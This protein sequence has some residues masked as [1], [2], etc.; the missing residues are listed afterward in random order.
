MAKRVLDTQ[1]CFSGA[2][3]GFLPLVEVDFA[4]VNGAAYVPPERG[5]Y[6]RINAARTIQ[7]LQDVPELIH[8]YQTSD[9][10]I[11]L[12]SNQIGTDES[13]ND[14]GNGRG[15]RFKNEGTGAIYIGT[16]A[17]ILLVTVP[18]LYSVNVQASENQQWDI[19][20]LSNENPSALPISVITFSRSQTVSQG[21]YLYIGSNLTSDCGFPLNAVTYVSAISVTN[22]KSMVAGKSATFRLQKRIAENVF[23]DIIG[24]D[25]TIPAGSYKATINGLLLQLNTGDELCAYRINGDG[26]GN[27]N[28]CV[29]NAYTI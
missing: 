17:G 28:G 22:Q 14:A 5:N 16:S 23:T 7:L 3:F 4:A 26:G 27:V 11:R 12:P 29:Y 21:S 24:S 10:Y 13:G 9:A 25:V 8:T 1:H 6:R 18:P 2:A 20:A 15:I 19:F